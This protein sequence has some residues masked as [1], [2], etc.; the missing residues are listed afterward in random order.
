[1]MMMMV[2]MLF[3]QSIVQIHPH[4]PLIETEDRNSAD[5]CYAVPSARSSSSFTI[6]PANLLTICAIETADS[7]SVDVR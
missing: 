5:D 1:M 7:K 4:L 6:I 2:H 3:E